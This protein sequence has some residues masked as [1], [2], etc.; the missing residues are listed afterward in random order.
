MGQRNL[1]PMIEDHVWTKL[2]AE[3]EEAAR[4][5][6]VLAELL[7][8]SVLDVDSLEEALTYRISRKLGHH[9]VSEPYL[10]DLFREIFLD[11]PEIGQQARRDIIAIHQRDPACIG[12]LD[13][14]LFYKGFHTFRIM[15]TI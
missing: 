10:H 12:Y 11:N 2:Y 9:A 5:E 13:P 7:H 1:L 8:K 3:A 14:F 15:C 6:P 4:K